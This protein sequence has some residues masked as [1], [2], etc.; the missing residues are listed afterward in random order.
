MAEQVS[1]AAS[2]GRVVDIAADIR[3]GRC[4][5]T[6]AVQACLDRIADV[7]D[8]VIAWVSVD[9]AGALAA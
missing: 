3:A 2:P 8:E 5:P 4:T 9:S 7:D 6:D 1:F